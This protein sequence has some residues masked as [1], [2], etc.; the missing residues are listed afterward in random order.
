ML[1][2]VWRTNL[3]LTN[4]F[5]IPLPLHKCLHSFIREPI[6]N[7]IDV[8]FVLQEGD[9]ISVYSDVEEWLKV[10]LE[11]GTDC[12]LHIDTSGSAGNLTNAGLPATKVGNEGYG[13]HFEISNQKRNT[14]D[15]LV[16]NPWLYDC[17]TW[18]GAYGAKNVS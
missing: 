18:E 6:E 13:W 12:E 16:G 4:Y 3:C 7:C 2:L 8:D 5:P 15:T 17:E 9:K 11:I 14:E 10:C 1:S